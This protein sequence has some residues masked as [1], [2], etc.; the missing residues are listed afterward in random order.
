MITYTPR[1]A[2]ETAV[3]K[4]GRFEL[5]TDTA[6]REVVCAGA[7][8][9]PRV[10]LLRSAEGLQDLIGAVAGE[11]ST[12]FTVTAGD[13]WQLEPEAVHKPTTVAAAEEY[14]VMGL[15]PLTLEGRPLRVVSGVDVVRLFLLPWTMPATTLNFGREPHFVV[16][17]TRSLVGEWV[18]VPDGRRGV[19]V[20]LPEAWVG[21]LE[22]QARSGSAV[23]FRCDV[24]VPWVGD[25]GLSNATPTTAAAYEVV[26]SAPLDGGTAAGAG[27]QL[28]VARLPVAMTEGNVVRPV[29]VPGDL[30][31]EE[32]H[33]GPWEAEWQ[34][35]SNF[36][37]SGLN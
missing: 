1:T 30:Q 29:L 22:R 16:T 15:R 21:V 13:P 20:G 6:G 25:D 24:P 9:L 36:S 4:S 31:V 12:V 37:M 33:D 8:R 14:L 34:S 35:A 5:T 23:A 28:W 11:E 18:G 19:V 3:L 7:E 10:V 32:V 26:G 2:L 17:S 27:T